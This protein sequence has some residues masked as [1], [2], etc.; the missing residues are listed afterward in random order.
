MCDQFIRHAAAGNHQVCLA[1][2]DH[3]AAVRCTPCAAVTPESHWHRA[4]TCRARRGGGMSMRTRCHTLPAPTCRAT[5]HTLPAPTCRARRGGGMS[6]TRCHTLPA[7]TSSSNSCAASLSPD[8]SASSSELRLQAPEQASWQR[9][10]HMARRQE[11]ADKRSGVGDC[12]HAAG[13]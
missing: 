4:R 12:E 2:A 7:P 8:S 11:H 3:L 13:A 9:L 5:Y 1:H 6:R 10:Q